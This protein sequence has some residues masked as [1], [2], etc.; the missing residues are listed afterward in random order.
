MLRLTGFNQNENP[1]LSL[2][3]AG[4][5][6]SKRVTVPAVE[7]SCAA[8]PSMPRSELVGAEVIGSSVSGIELGPE[9]EYG[10]LAWFSCQRASRF[11]ALTLF[12]NPAMARNARQAPNNIERRGSIV[13]SVPKSSTELHDK[14][15]R[16]PYI[17]KN[18]AAYQGV[19][20]VLIVL[21]SPGHRPAY[22]LSFSYV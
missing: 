16:R 22:R 10:G 1:K 19:A 3:N 7:V 21:E 6:A 20:N 8:E 9:S 2:C 4:P 12:S 5:V 18:F 15:T 13:M 11:A 17:H 14:L